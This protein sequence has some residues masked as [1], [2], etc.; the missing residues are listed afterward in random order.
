MAYSEFKTGNGG[1]E[2]AVAAIGNSQLLNHSVNLKAAAG[3]SDIIYVGG[4]GVTIITGY[5]L[6][7]GNELIL[8]IDDP[9][10]V[11]VIANP[12]QNE[13]QTITY[14]SGAANEEFK[15]SYG[16]QTTAAL[17][18]DDT[19][20]TIETAFEGL[21]SV[22]AGNGTITGGA[23]GPWTLEWTGTKAKM[24]VG[25]PTASE[26]GVNETQTITYSGNASTDTYYLTWDSQD[27]SELAIDDNNAAIKAALADLTGLIAGDITMSGGPAPGTPVVVTFGN[28]V[29]RTD[30]A[31]ITGTGGTDEEQT[32]T[33]TS[34]VAGDT[35][36]ITWDG[37]T[38]ATRI[39]YDATALTV[40]SAL[41]ALSNI[42]VGDVIVT[43]S[44]GGPWTLTWGG[45][46]INTDVAEPTGDAGTNEVQTI[47]PTTLAPTGGTWDLDWNGEGPTAVAY[48]ATAAD[49]L[50]VIIAF[51]T[52][53]SGD[54][55]VTGSDG[56]PYEVTF[57]VNLGLQ[58]VVDITADGD[59]LSGRPTVLVTTQESVAPVNEVQTI[60]IPGGSVIGTF[61]L[62]YDG[63]TTG[64]ADYNDTGADIDTLLEALSNIGA[65][66]VGVTGAAG[67]P[68]VVTFTGALAGGPRVDITGDGA[69]LTSHNVT[70]TETV[71]G[72]VGVN[73]EQTIEIPSIVVGGTFTIT[74]NGQT[75]ATIAY[76]A[77]A[78]DVEAA[79]KLLTNI[80]AG[81]LTVTGGPGPGANWVCEFTGALGETELVLMGGD[82]T[83][84]EGH[85]VSV[86]ETTPGITA[87]NEQQTLTL[88]TG[89][90]GGTFVLTLGADP[91]TAIAWNVSNANLKT[92]L[93]TNIAA[94]DT[95]AVTGGGPY[96]IEFQ[97]GQAG[98]DVDLMT[99][100]TASLT[101][102]DPTVAE[103]VTGHTATFTPATTVAGNALTVSIA[104]TQKGVTKTV[105]IAE[106]QSASKES[107]YSWI[108]M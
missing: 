69:N 18:Y 105:S 22:G 106:A 86:V 62:T 46:Q 3:N 64:P 100:D 49:V 65:G 19:G 72:G 93:E 80:G 84:L 9:A 26:I 60:S 45:A 77:S 28:L 30:V 104:E 61:A 82:G 4:S 41:E 24:S 75:T 8:F 52:P 36:S 47:T 57:L 5:E 67:G 31:A 74:Y 78:G 2:V 58:T 1:A 92:D 51:A 53:V 54:L 88:P 66:D 38:T 29:A 37:Q 12:S 16:G 89:S 20:A 91:G 44:D 99:C 27:T 33:L 98:T 102:G 107:K 6:S 59:L 50:A 108:G 11:Y 21:S 68:W 73:E 76:N 96:V 101:G 42:A 13:Q 94:I 17:A 55:T 25:A 15:L 79:L 85:P 56:G 34:T 10:K 43:G 23:G 70:I 83:L 63:Q 103:T 48:D 90:N 87:V 32:I 39:A 71:T 35:F 7:A 97:G 95:V 40:Q 14:N 81:D